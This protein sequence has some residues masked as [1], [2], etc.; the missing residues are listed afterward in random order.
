MQQNRALSRRDLLK[1][2]GLSAVGLGL[3]IAPAL[4]PLFAQEAPAPA[5]FFRFGVGDFQLTVISDGSGMLNTS[6]LGAN[7]PEGAVDELFAANG[8]PTGSYPNAIQVLHVNTGSNQVLIDT[9]RGSANGSV[10]PTLDLLGVSRED[11]DTVIISHFHG[12]HIGGAATDGSATFPNARYVYSQPD[13]DFL[14]AAPAD[15]QGAQ[16]AKTAME[17]LGDQLEF[18]VAEDEVVS[19]IQAVATPGHTPGHMSFL[20]NSNG[21]QLLHLVDSV[22]NNVA[23][24]QHPEWFVA[25]DSIPEQAVESRRSILGRA[26][27]EQ[28]QVFGYH[29]TFPGLG[30]I[31]PDGEAYRYVPGS[32]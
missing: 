14:Q 19:G 29:F 3:G 4:R 17:S 23:S 7:A 1:G 27:S 28:I 20:I 15:N 13:W 10:L 22:L 21:E 30:F 25:F 26:A 31:L 6:I 5:A 2:F 24:V 18:Y 32:F 9:G 8:L 12:D 11:I 16:N